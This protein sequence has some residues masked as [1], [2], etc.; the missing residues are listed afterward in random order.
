M[1]NEGQI[2]GGPVC[3]N[4]FVEK[5]EECDCGTVEVCQ[6]GLLKMSQLVSRLQHGIT[7]ID[8]C[9]WGYMYTLPFKSCE[10]L[11]TVKTA[12]LLN[13]ITI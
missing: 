8:V 7:K 10:F 5:G 2:Y 6:V 1:P 12:L 11:N 9:I 3:G 4:A 13:V